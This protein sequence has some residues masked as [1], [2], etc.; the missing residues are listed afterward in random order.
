M[1]YMIEIWIYGKGYIKALAIGKKRAQAKE[2][3]LLSRYSWYDLRTYEV[4]ITRVV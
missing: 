1:L 4:K 2:V 3:E